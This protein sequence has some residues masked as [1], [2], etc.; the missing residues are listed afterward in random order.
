M[1]GAS[2]FL[3]IGGNNFPQNFITEN[4]NATSTVGYYGTIAQTVYSADYGN[5]TFSNGGSTAKTFIDNTTV[6]G[7][8]LINSGA[9][10]DPNS[11][12][13]TLAGN[14][15]NNGTYTPT[16]TLHL[17]GITKTITGST[18]FNTILVSGTYVVASGTNTISGD[19]VVETGA[20]LNFGSNA[21]SLDGDLTVNGSVTSNGIATFTGTR[22]QTFQII[23]A[24]VSAS[25]GVINFNGSVAPVFNS[26]TSPAFATLNINNTAG[27][28]PSVPWTV[29]FACNIAAGSSFNGGALTHT[30]YGNFTNNGTVTSNGELRFLPSPPF[31]AAATI[32]LDGVS[33]VSTGKVVFGG[34][35]PITI[36]D[37]NP[38]FYNVSVTNTNVAGVTAPNGWT[39]SNELFIG[40]GATFNSGTANTHTLAGNLTNNGTFNGQ[41]STVTFTGTPAEINGLG[42]NNFY[43]LTVAASA[44]LSLNRA[45]N[46]SKDFV[47]DGLFTPDGRTVTFNGTTASVISGLAGSVTFDELEQNKTGATTTLSVPVTVISELTL[48]SGIINTTTVNLL[49]LVDEAISTSGN[50]TSFVDGPM[51]K[52]GNDTFVFP[53]GDG[54]IWARLEITSPV[55]VTDAY[56]AQYFATSYS[57]TTSMAASPSPALNN[58]SSIEYWTCNRN[59]GTSNV[60]VKLYWENAARSVILGY[61]PDLVVARWNGSA[62]ENAG[63]SAITGASPGNVTSNTVSSF[64]TF[65]FGSLSGASPLPIVLLHF[66]AAVNNENQVDIEWL[67]ATE[68]NNDYFRIERTR[69]GVSFETVAIVDGAGNSTQSLHYTTTDAHPYNGV[70]YY[71]LTQV[72]FNGM[73][74]YSEIVAVTLTSTEVSTT[75][76]S[77]SIYP[78]PG[79]GQDIH[80]AMNVVKGQELA[81]S[82]IDAFGKECFYELVTAAEDG[83]IA[84]TLPQLKLTPGIYFIS[85]M[86]QKE[87]YNQKLIVE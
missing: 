74:S 59:S 53:L 69:D 65:T 56:T 43:N 22:V 40:N 51:K 67:T 83:A 11:S 48:T 38:S 39:V 54:T 5:L 87:R 6:N 66:D 2:S 49:T 64:G 18:S 28:T 20:S 78:N 76:F 27:I 73:Q 57:N 31:S 10:I 71:R 44:D 33:F 32:K 24:I 26:N 8:L 19:L 25:T 13:I 52:I 60:K 4:I 1:L 12:T 17:T 14:F 21:V 84:Y 37:V 46:I 9:T 75:E 34:T 72:D 80:L 41:T 3:L 58:V 45:I 42:T 50:S 61:S 35:S 68:T 23:N 62:W 15:T 30:F 86:A 82:V 70:S 63:Q 29:Y 16:G 79:N 77:F 81:V 36:T 85:V 47:I 55:A 7:N